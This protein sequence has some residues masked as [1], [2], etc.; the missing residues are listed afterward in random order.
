MPL[1]WHDALASV[2]GF[3]NTSDALLALYALTFLLDICTFLNLKN[4]D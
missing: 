2:P 1:T 4:Q 3:T